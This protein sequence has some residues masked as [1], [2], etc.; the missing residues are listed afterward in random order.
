MTW[1]ADGRWQA[2]EDQWLLHPQRCVLA[3]RSL[4]YKQVA[5]SLMLS[6]FIYLFKKYYRADL[7]SKKTQESHTGTKCNWTKRR[8]GWEH[9]GHCRRKDGGKLCTRCL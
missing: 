2:A 5:G 4:R 7:E 1:V 8:R 6:T 3:R 9:P